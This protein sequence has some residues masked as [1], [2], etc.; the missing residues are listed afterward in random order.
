MKNIFLFL[1]LI[2]S[3]CEI[4]NQEEPN[5]LDVKGCWRGEIIYNNFQLQDTVSHWICTKPGIFGSFQEP[6][7]KAVL[8]SNE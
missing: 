5:S 6:E 7:F 1:F 3:F 4:Y 8:F 2:I